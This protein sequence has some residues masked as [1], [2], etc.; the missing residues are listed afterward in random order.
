MLSGESP[1]ARMASKVGAT[2]DDIVSTIIASDEY[3]SRLCILA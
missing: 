2:E 1:P 3:L